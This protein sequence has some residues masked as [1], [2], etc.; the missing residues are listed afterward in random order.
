MPIKLSL[1][2]PS[3]HTRRNTFLPS[4]ME[5][6]YNQYDKLTPEQQDSV[7]ILVLSENKKIML[8]E[9]RNIMV[10]M[11]QGEYIGFIDDD[12]RVSP[13]YISEILKATET[14]ADCITFTASVSINGADAKPCYYSKDYLKDYNK[15]GAYYR[16]PNHICVL[17]KGVS[18]NATFPSIKYWEDAAYAKLLLPHIKTEHKINKVLYYYDY[19]EN[20]TEAQEDLYRKKN[21]VSRNADAQVDIVILSKADTTDMIDM[22]QNTIDTAIKGANGLPIQVYVVEQAPHIQYDNAITIYHN[23][24]DDFC[25]NANCNLGVRQG[26]A[27]YIMLC[28]N[29]LVF[30]NGYLHELLGENYPLVS[31]HEPNDVRQKPVYKNTIGDTNG[32]H[33]SGW[34]FMIKRELWESIGGFDEEFKFWFSDDAVIAQCVRAGVKPMLVKNAVV[35]HLGS[36]T[37]N[38]LDPQK[39]D[40]YTW[41]LAARFNRKYGQ[42]KFRRNP[43]Y[44]E[45]KSKN[46]V[47]VAISSR[48]REEVTANAVSLWKEFYPDAQIIVVEDNGQT[49]L[50]IAKTKNLCIDKLLQSGATHCFLADNDIYPKDA[51]GVLRYIS[52]PYKHLCLSFDSKYNGAR[53]SNEVF[54][55][56]QIDGHNIFNYPCGPLLYIHRSILLAG[57]R[58]DEAYGTWGMEHADFSMQVFTEG[59]IPHPYIDIT[60]SL[61]HFH[62][63]DYYGEVEGTVH[64]DER[65]RNIVKN[66]QYFKSKW[67]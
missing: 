13:E 38:T 3:T 16:I 30:N 27:P 56:E 5:Q 23:T 39:K 51:M 26:S 18:Q 21:R 50:G 44:D 28:N 53:I 7:E 63:M 9:K 48:G 6:V 67:G 61:N 19:N 32:L 45:W 29:D 24:G 62:C 25:Y 49:P 42:N 31:P 58:F 33:F 14:D 66:T 17:K 55:K 4:I 54:I 11:A 36:T 20:T 8:G 34:C 52:S 22:T 46:T 41:G 35:H 10:D 43:Y 15:P 12:D 47:A 59:L 65:R 60:N 64:E 40:D 57:I 2:I 1:L 37:F